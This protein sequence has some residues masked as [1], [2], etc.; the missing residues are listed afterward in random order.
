MND[1]RDRLTR[2]AAESSGDRLVLIGAALTVIWL[3]LILIA[4]FFGGSDGGTSFAGRLLGL[5]GIVAPIALIWLAVW[6][7][8]NL[9]A[10][11]SEADDLRLTLAR[12]KASADSDTGPVTRPEPVRATVATPARAAPPVRAAAPEAQASLPLQEP[13]PQELSAHELV[14]ALNFPDGPDDTFAITSLRKALADREL[15]KLIRAAQDVVTLLASHGV[16][17]EDLA[18]DQ[19]YP[20]LWRNFIAGAR[21]DAVADIALNAD[22]ASLDKTASMLKWDEVFRDAAHH[23][24]RRFDRLLSDAAR[25]C[26]DNVLAAVVDTRSGRAFTLLAQ[27]T[28]MIGGYTPEPDDA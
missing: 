11:K 15:A 7:S 25:D 21:G 2:L 22:E 20:A 19:L 8:R 24:L 28:G 27:V 14:A 12:M 16:Y 13:P 5:A 9:Q 1:V 23:F 17:M 3:G 4:S 10:L 26:D 6:Q 18:A